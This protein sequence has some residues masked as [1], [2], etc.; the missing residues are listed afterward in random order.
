M[1][2]LKI[3]E[4]D[5]KPVWCPG[6]GHFSVL[7]ALK[8]AAAALDLEPHKIVVTSGIG[9]SSNI[10]SYVRTYGFHGLHGRPVPVAVGIKNA[11]PGL[12]VIAAAGDGDEYGIG[13]NHVVHAAR[14]NDDIKVIVMNNEIYGLTT[15][16]ASPT[17]KMGQVTK[18]TP[19]GSILYPIQPIPTLLGAGAT[20]IA[21][22][23][24]GDPKHLSGLLQEAINHRGFAL[25]DVA[26]ACVTWNNLQDTIRE[27]VYKLEDRGYKPDNEIEAFKAAMDESGIPIGIFYRTEEKPTFQ[28]L[29]VS[30]K[31]ATRP[32]DGVRNLTPEESAQ[33]M[34]PCY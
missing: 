23:F 22:G 6:C 17:S 19:N 31:G 11:N 9:C 25:I 32:I 29:E 1:R 5:T 34:R 30:N 18:S 14:R 28:E 7:A 2:S 8:S 16:Q 26:S 13:F 20:F 21:R 24:S 3:F 4:S 33:I 15:G 12:T 10:P 27:K